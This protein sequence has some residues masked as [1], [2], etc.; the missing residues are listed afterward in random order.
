MK[1]Y[2]SYYLPKSS[3]ITTPVMFQTD[4]STAFQKELARCDK[5]GYDIVSAYI[6]GDREISDISKEVRS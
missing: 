1:Y 4:S 5:Y 3:R 6:I 2:L